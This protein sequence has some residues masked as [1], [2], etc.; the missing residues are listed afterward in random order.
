LRPEKAWKGLASGPVS[1]VRRDAADD[2]DRFG[3]RTMKNWPA[4]DAIDRNA[5]DQVRL[6]GRLTGRTG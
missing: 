3:R 5:V 2:L 1:V 4:A 6:S